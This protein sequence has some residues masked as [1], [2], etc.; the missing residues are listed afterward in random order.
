MIALNS[1]V[2]GG[3]RPCSAAR[4]SFDWPVLGRTRRVSVSLLFVGGFTPEGITTHND[5]KTYDYALGVE[6][7]GLS[8]QGTRGGRPKSWS[9]VQSG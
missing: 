8:T 6:A 5:A 2:G 3:K 4:G 9:G 1:A 7:I